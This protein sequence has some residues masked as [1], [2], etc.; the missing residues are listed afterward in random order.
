MRQNSALRGNRLNINTNLKVISCKYFYFQ[1]RAYSLD[2][3]WKIN[4][5]AGNIRANIY[6]NFMNARL[7]IRIFF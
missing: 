4:S 6:Q 3:T 5:K 1:A 7:R 2:T